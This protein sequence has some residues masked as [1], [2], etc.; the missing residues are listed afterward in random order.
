MATFLPTDR[1]WLEQVTGHM[2]RKCV[3]M[4]PGPALLSVSRLP[5]GKQVLIPLC[6]SAILFGLGAG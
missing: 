2:T 1:V 5:L 4:S 3:S 6:P